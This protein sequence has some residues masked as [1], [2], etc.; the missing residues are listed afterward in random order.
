[1][2][3]SLIAGGMATMACHLVLVLAIALFMALYGI[4][5]TTHGV[6]IILHFMVITTTMAVA[7]MVAVYGV[8]ATGAAVSIP[9]EQ[10]MCKTTDLDQ[11]EVVTMGTPVIEVM[12]MMP[13]FLQGR[14]EH[15]AIMV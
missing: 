15:K 8:V 3:L 6:V 10:P 11:T 1:M 14:P 13:I 5:H 9:A 7:I 12:E 4:P 2:T